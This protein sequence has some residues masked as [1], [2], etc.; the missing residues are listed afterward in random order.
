MNL[1]PPD[2]TERR[3]AIR[4]L[5]NHYRVLL[6]MQASNIYTSVE[7]LVDLNTR[8]EHVEG[9]ASGH[10]MRLTDAERRAKDLYENWTP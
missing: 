2:A 9:T 10:G 3:W 4:R 1:P 5:N 7:R 6:T 8:W